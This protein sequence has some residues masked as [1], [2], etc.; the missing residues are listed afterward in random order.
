MDECH[1]SPDYDQTKALIGAHEQKVAGVGSIKTDVRNASLPLY[2]S[3]PCPLVNV[4]V[5]HDH[6]AKKILVHAYHFRGKVR[7]S[8]VLT[9]PKQEESGDSDLEDV[10]VEAGSLRDMEAALEK[11]R[12]LK[13]M[14]ASGL[15]SKVCARK[16]CSTVQ[17]SS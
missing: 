10:F 1:T 15:P 4:S 14:L 12:A 11:A 9:R 3:V 6:E 16:K 5:K 13:A 17:S 2:T 8:F 7:I